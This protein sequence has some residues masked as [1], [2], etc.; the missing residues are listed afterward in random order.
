MVSFKKFVGFALAEHQPRSPEENAMV[1]RL[2]MW[3]MTFGCISQGK[4]KDTKAKYRNFL[5]RGLM[6][7]LSKSSNTWTSRTLTMLMSPE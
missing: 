7:N 5:A 3:F 1:R 4:L 2:D 6:L